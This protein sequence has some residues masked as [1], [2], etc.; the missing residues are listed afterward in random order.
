[1]NIE[2]GSKLTQTSG[3]PGSF[4]SYYAPSASAVKE[5]GT[6]SDGADVVLGWGRWT[7]V[8]KDYMGTTTLTNAH[9]VIGKPMSSADITAMNGYTGVFEAVGGTKATAA[10]GAIG[11]LDSAKL[12]VAF[13]GGGVQSTALDLK[14][15]I[16]GATHAFL[17][18]WGYGAG[19][20]KFQSSDSIEYRGMVAQG[21]KKAGLVYSFDGGTTLGAVNGAAGLN[22][23]SKS[24][25]VIPN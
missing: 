21:G 15:K 19:G 9:Y 7:T 3:F 12:T 24:V 13:G 16:G 11:T 18:Q 22:R 2:Q 6:L 25:T 14:V 8:T 1:V 10:N 5:V 4:F 17:N 20:G 23:T